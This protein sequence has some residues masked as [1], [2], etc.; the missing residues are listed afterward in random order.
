MRPA[1]GSIQCTGVTLGLSATP[2]VLAPYTSQLIATSGYFT[3]NLT[4]GQVT[5][6]IGTAGLAGA[7]DFIIIDGDVEG[8][9]NNVVTMAVY[10]NGAPTPF[11]LSMT[12]QGNG[13]P[14]TLNASGLSYSA[15]PGDAV[16]EIRVSGDSGT[17]IFT[18]I[19]LICQAQPVG[20]FT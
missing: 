11:A 2:I 17:Y 12:T 8:P 15:A 10:K 3:T 16:Y 13:R 6:L 5:R 1:Y 19:D 18:N 14:V 4:T 20:S 7:T 9:N